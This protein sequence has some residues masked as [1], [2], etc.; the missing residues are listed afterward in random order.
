MNLMNSTN[1]A[2][3]SALIAM[4]ARYQE[5]CAMD[6]TL[7]YKVMSRAAWLSFEAFR[8]AADAR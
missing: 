1:T 2:A 7:G 4:E 6:A 5:M 8:A 3:L